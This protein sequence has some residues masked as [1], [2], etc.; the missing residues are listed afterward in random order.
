MSSPCTDVC[1]VAQIAALLVGGAFI[2]WWMHKYLPKI[3]LDVRQRFNEIV[4]KPSHYGVILAVMLCNA[5]IATSFVQV[6][7]RVFFL[8][9]QLLGWQALLHHGDNTAELM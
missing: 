3:I 9:P 2:W 7:Y 5:L 1:A 8:K 6:Y 4:V